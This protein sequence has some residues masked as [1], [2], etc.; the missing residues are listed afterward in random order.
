MIFR[1]PITFTPFELKFGYLNYGGKNYWYKAPFNKSVIKASDLPVL[2]DSTQ[3]EF[4]I[5]DELK[6]RRGI[7]IELD[8][9]RTNFPHLLINQNYIDLQLGIGLQYID[10]GA[11]PSLPSKEKD[12]EEW[13]SQSSRGNYFF[14]PRSTG[15]NINSSLTWQFIQNNATYFYHSFGINS[16]SLYQSEGGEINLSGLGYTES[17]GLGSKYIF[18]EEKRNFDYTIGIELKWNRLYMNSINSSDT[19][20]P[21]YGIDLRSSGLFLTT[22]IQFGGRHSDGDIAYSHMMNHNYISASESFEY[23]LAKEKNH[24]KRQKA[25]EMLEYCQSKIPLQQLNIGIENLFLSDFNEAVKWFNKAE[26]EAQDEL[27]QEVQLNRKIIAQALLD[28]VQTYRNKMSVA[29]AEEL[30]L[31]AKELSPNLKNSNYIL[32]KTYIDKG[33]LNLSIGNLSEAL[34]NYK[35]A[36]QTDSSLEPLIILE[37]KKL[38]NAFIKDAY[39]ASL[40]NDL[41]LAINSLKSVIEI[42]PRIENE[43]YSYIIKLEDKLK[44]QIDIGNKQY[45]KDY[46]QQKKY[47]NNNLIKEISIGMSVD[48]IENIKGK[49]KYIDKNINANIQFEMW[50]FPEDSSLSRLYF[51]NNILIKIEK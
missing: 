42:N 36:L 25:L 6:N 26:A 35:E 48:E 50:S 12:M 28:S 46:I 15:I 33:N 11:N 51:K 20:S 10:F 3:Y 32:A 9:V 34:K 47:P 39:H 21:I 31:I 24:G 14:H 27:K 45:L 49:P 30:A 44:N 1:K 22:G 37:Y 18:E 19:L 13:I 38:A 16:T 29:E 8:I 40:N 7:F 2:L 17:F 43:L 41:Y 23:F 4:N 5:I